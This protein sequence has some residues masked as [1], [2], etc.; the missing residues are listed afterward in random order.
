MLLMASAMSMAVEQQDVAALMDDAKQAMKEAQYNRAIQS[1][2]K[3][4]ALPDNAYRRDAQELLALAYER[5]GQLDQAKLE[6]QRYLQLYPE[7]D[8]AERVRQRLAGI[9]TAAWP[10]QDA[11]KKLR[12]EKQA[13]RNEWQ[14]YGSLSQYLRRDVSTF[15]DQPSVVGN[16]SLTTALDVTSKG[17]SGD[18]DIKTRV[19]GSYLYDLDNISGHQQQ[20]SYLYLDLNQRRQGWSGS[21]GRQ[22]AN[23]GGVLGRYDGIDLAMRLSPNYSVGVVAGMPV[24]RSTETSPDSSRRFYGVN[25]ETGP[26]N[27]HWELNGYLIQQQ[28]DGLL[29]RRAVGGELRYLHPERML[30]TLLDYDISY[31]ALNIASV[32]GSWIM[33]DKTSY[34][35]L[36]DYR[37]GPALT[38]RNALIGQSVTT[39]TALSLSYSEEQIRQLAQ[40]RTPRST[41]AMVGVSR[42]L[43]ERYRLDADFSVSNVGA[44]PDSGGVLASDSSGNDYYLSTQLTGSSFFKEGDV[45]IFGLRLGD[46]AVNRST[47]LLASSRLPIA[48]SWYINPRLQLGY[49]S[50]TASSDSQQS[51]YPS[52]R[53]EYNWSRFS[54]FWFD[55]GYEWSQ[56]NL[57]LGNQNYT[58][59]SLEIGYRLGF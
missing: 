23:G 2:L 24:E 26:W 25:I 33:P 20:L 1:Y 58:N 15:E 22:R 9:V 4:L 50:Y 35:L 31:G 6:Y 36:L 39:L 8:G 7:G 34:N 28:A 41:L 5:N 45:T 11:S 12:P 43:S 32:Q 14:H 55:G 13:Q 44:T 59:Y 53:V 52:L 38:T 57:W 48:G 49:Q 42:P 54:Q 56:R 19:S 47:T 29:D 30:Y 3:L 51:L 21:I 46:S 37:N 16:Y 17:R 10:E 27:E 40:D 18:L